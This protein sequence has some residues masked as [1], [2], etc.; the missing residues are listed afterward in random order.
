MISKYDSTSTKVFKIM[1]YELIAT[2]VLYIAAFVLEFLICFCTCG[3]FGIHTHNGCFFTE[4]WTG[5][6]F[7][8]TFVF[9]TIAGVVI[10]VV[11]GIAVTAQEA[12]DRAAKRRAAEAEAAARAN[13]EQREKNAK[14]FAHKHKMVVGNCELNKGNGERVKLS[15]SYKVVEAQEKIWSS[16]NEISIPLQELEDIVSETLSMKGD[17]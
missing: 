8:N 17:A 1:G 6:T 2:P 9:L 14:D 3:D 13:K 16:L 10:G 4:F 15:P 12:S 7:G 11:Y 5:A